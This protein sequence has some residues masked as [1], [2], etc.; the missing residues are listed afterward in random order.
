MDVV[1]KGELLV[2]YFSVIV[3]F[4]NHLYWMPLGVWMSGPSRPITTVFELAGTQGN[5]AYSRW[6]DRRGIG[7]QI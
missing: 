7:L 6:T 1:G 3:G 4:D 2:G 5:S